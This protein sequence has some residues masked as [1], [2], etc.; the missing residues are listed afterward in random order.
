MSVEDMLADVTAK[1]KA[2]VPTLPRVMVSSGLM[3]ASV[4]AARMAAFDEALFMKMAQT[5]WD[6]T[7]PLDACAVRVDLVMGCGQA[8]D[9]VNRIVEDQNGTTPGVAG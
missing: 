4:C 7:K 8:R 6:S 9:M 5:A 1:A 3:M 2:Y